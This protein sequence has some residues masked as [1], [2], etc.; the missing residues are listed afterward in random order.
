MATYRVMHRDSENRGLWEDTD[1]PDL[2]QAIWQIAQ[3]SRAD[4]QADGQLVAV[5]PLNSDGTIQAPS[6]VSAP[7]TAE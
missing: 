1:A 3:K 2:Y 6:P 5:A 7:V 4:S